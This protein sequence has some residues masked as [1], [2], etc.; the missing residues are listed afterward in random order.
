[1]SGR[2]DAR[3]RANGAGFGSH[4]SS[5]QNDRAASRQRPEP[6]AIAEA[7][8][9]VLGRLRLVLGSLFTPANGLRRW[10]D[11]IKAISREHVQFISL[12]LVLSLKVLHPKPSNG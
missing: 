11:A 2:T 5:R 7:S 4:V 6:R 3:C 12:D 10:L 9:E 1:M 8:N